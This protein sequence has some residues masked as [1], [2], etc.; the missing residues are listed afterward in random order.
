MRILGLV[1]IFLIETE[2]TK[3]GISGRASSTSKKKPNLQRPVIQ[4]RKN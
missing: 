1:N 3:K 2:T 4:L